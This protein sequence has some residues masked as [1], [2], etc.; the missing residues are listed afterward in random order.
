MVWTGKRYEEANC[1]ECRFEAA[2]PKDAIK[3]AGLNDP[4]YEVK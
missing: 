1:G 3:K 2:S 4:M